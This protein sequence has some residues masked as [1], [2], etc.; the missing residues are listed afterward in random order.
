MHGVGVRARSALQARLV[1]G[2]FCSLVFVSV[3]AGRF[4]GRFP[5]VFALLMGVAEFVSNG[6]ISTAQHT[7]F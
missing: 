5:C 3:C 1:R 2:L 4:A 7:L 6:F